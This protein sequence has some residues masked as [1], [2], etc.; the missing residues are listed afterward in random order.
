MNVTTWRTPDSMLGRLLLLARAAF[1]LPIALF[2]TPWKRSMRLARLILRVIPTYTMVSPTRLATLYELA[3]RASA[4]EVPGDIVECGSWNGGSAAVMAVASREGVPPA[5]PR[6]VWVFDSFQGFPP[7][8]GQDGTEARAAVPQGWLTGDADKV[9]AIMRRFQIPSDEVTVVPGWFDETLPAAEISQIVLLHIDAD[10]YHSVKR[11][12]ETFYEKVVEG[13]VVVID[14][15]YLWEGCRK[16]VDDFF[17]E[18]HIRDVA[19]RRFGG[20]TPWSGGIAVYF[21]KPRARGRADGTR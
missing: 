3:E 15:Y 19:L 13:G 4:M 18:Q 14:D 21:E 7:A 1:E 9:R 2:K 11:V 20:T 10:R 6:H 5:S 12:L 17:S 8:K 16:A